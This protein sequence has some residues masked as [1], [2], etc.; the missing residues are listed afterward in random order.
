MAKQVGHNYTGCYMLKRLIVIGVDICTRC[1]MALISHN[2]MLKH[3]SQQTMVKSPQYLTLN[4]QLVNFGGG[5]NQSTV[6]SLKTGERE[7][8]WKGRVLVW[9]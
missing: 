1:Q 5:E 7:D 3:I 4:E 6:A 8:V 9:W 2:T